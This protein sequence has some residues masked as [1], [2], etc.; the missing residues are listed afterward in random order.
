MAPLQL[1]Q[2]LDVVNLEPERK[3]LEHMGHLSSA[4]DNVATTEEGPAH[5]LAALPRHAHWRLAHSRS[6]PSV[7]LPGKGQ[8]R[9]LCGGAGRGA[10]RHT[11]AQC[12]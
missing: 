11:V 9:G 5:L 8:F 4:V 1:V 7:H 12:S 6:L 3:W 2:V 10:Q